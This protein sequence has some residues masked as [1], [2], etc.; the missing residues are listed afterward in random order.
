LKYD[1]IVTSCNRF[2]LLDKTLLSFFRYADVKP[3]RVI[4]SEDSGIDIPDRIIQL[5]PQESIILN[6]QKRGQIASIDLCLSFVE[7]DYFFHLE[8]DWEFYRTGFIEESF[9]V[10]KN[11]DIINHW[12]RERNDTN[13]HPVKNDCLILNHKRTWHGFTFNPTLKRMKDYRILKSYSNFGS[14]IWRAWENEIAIGKYYKDRGM[15]ATIAKQGYVKHIGENR[16]VTQG[17]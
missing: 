1:L 15:Y 7:Q 12:L 13:G 4:I 5:L 9:N 2:D 3:Q 16:H 10:L 6:N 11:R 8:D 14:N 17:Q